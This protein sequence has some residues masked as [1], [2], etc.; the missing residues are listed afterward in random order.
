MSSTLIPKSL[1]IGPVFKSKIL[2]LQNGQLLQNPRR[3]SG[4]KL[5]N[6]KL[7]INALNEKCSF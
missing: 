2:S 4:F 7:M 3:L 5:Q 1:L 6:L